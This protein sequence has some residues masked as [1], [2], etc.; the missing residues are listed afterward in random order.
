MR[1]LPK[2]DLEPCVP[3]TLCVDCEAPAAGLRKNLDREPSCRPCEADRL[4][5]I[6]MILEAED[7]SIAPV[8][9][10]LFDG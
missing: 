3:G 8:Q 4:A 1:D 7:E 5:M 2:I 9:T 10:V 6:V